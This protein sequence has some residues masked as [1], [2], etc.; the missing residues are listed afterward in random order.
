[1]E[2]EIAAWLGN[3]S[4]HLTEIGKGLVEEVEITANQL[5]LQAREKGMMDN[6]GFIQD[7]DM[8]FVPRML[9]RAE[10]GVLSHGGILPSSLSLDLVTMIADISVGARVTLAVEAEGM[11]SPWVKNSL[12]L[13]VHTETEEPVQCQEYFYETFYWFFSFTVHLFVSKT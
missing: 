4:F 1:M 3:V 5:L 9:Q 10:L 8:K 11:I 7:L 13:S 12:D 2:L 6:E